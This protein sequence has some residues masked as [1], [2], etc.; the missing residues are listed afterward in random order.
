MSIEVEVN[1]RIPRVKVPVLDEK[2]YP[3]DNGTVRFTKLI[4]VP[5]IPKPGAT[6]ELSTSSGKMF[7][8][9]VTRADWNDERELFILS[10]KY[11]EPIDSRRSM[12]RPLQRHRVAGE[13]AA[14]RLRTHSR[15][16]QATR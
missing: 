2:G 5:S 1:L 8:C 11:A 10:C 7:A 6:L 15:H 16:S 4:K 14:L 9:E 13:A 12:R 3:I